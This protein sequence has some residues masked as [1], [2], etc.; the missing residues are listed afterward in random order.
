VTTLQNKYDNLCKVLNEQTSELE[1]LYERIR[2]AR[3]VWGMAC[4]CACEACN[5]LWTALQRIAKDSQ[6][7]ATSQGQP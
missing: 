5:T 4:P 3:L 7:P 1:G 2:T 6:E